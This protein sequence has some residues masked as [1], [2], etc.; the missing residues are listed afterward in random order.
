M[1]SCDP[2]EHLLECLLMDSETPDSTIEEAEP[3]S[4]LEKPV[5]KAIIWVRSDAEPLTTWLSGRDELVVGRDAACDVALDAPLISRRHARLRRTGS[6][7][8]IE[9]LESR[10]GVNLNGEA[11]AQAAITTGDVL[12]IG[13]SVGMVLG[14][15]KNE[16]PVY[17]L[18]DEDLF[19]GPDLRNLL[20]QLH[21]AG[22]SDFPAVLEGP[23]GTGKEQFARAI[24]RRSQRT[25][26]F[27][28]INCSTYR[29]STAAAEL[30]G[31][32][33]GAFTGA[34]RANPGLV[35]A[36]ED[37]TLLL[38]E[39]T[40]LPLDVQPQLLRA[41]ENREVIPL[42][43]S[44]T[45]AVNVRFLGATQEPLRDAVEAGRFRA[46]LRARL[47]GLRIVMP[48]LA[49]RRGDVPFLFMYLL[50]KHAPNPPAPD[51]RVLERLCLYDWPLNV[52]E[53]VSL[54]KRLVAAFPDTKTLS[55]SQVTSQFPEIGSL[56]RPATGETNNVRS[57]TTPPG[58]NAPTPERR[59]ANPR[60]F[61]GEDLQALRAALER[62]QGNVASAA[63][64]LGISRQ[65]AYRMLKSGDT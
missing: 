51:A 27:L 12:R 26:P 30:F 19:G 29:P 36:A 11:V 56:A 9:D 33:K 61:Q 31:Y 43:E 5:R 39:I 60:A 55:L 13:A 64:E 8:F 22:T 38:D 57:G 53:M 59:R 3:S 46:D 18:L 25:G 37:G 10:N 21:I 34:E 65:R 20:G 50:K 58:A 15:I 7:W 32:R 28:A 54:V 35:R 48:P 49:A 52:R 14:F 63:A 6:S 24:H 45:M 16:E 4:D 42:G 2:M 47:E 40:D 44:Q 23:T 41:I 17:E 1:A 62:H